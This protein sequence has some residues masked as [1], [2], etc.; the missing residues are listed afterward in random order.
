MK[1]KRDQGQLDTWHK[2][3]KE[4]L[5]IN[6]IIIII[7]LFLYLSSRNL[8]L[9]ILKKLSVLCLPFCFARTLAHLFLPNLAGVIIQSYAL[10]G[11]TDIKIVFTVPCVLDY[12]GLADD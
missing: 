10:P 8:W 1:K 2:R 5:W 3:G 12:F 11:L 9:P 7:Q 6:H 4:L